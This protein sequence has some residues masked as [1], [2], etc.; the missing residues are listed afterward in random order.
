MGRRYSPH[1]PLRAVGADHGRGEL[2]VH[3]GCDLYYVGPL[4]NELNN[5]SLPRGSDRTFTLAAVPEPIPLNVVGVGLLGLSC[6]RR[7]A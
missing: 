7:R 5:D 3:D 2:A 1:R 4:Y 6:A